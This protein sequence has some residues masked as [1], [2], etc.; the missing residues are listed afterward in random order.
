MKNVSN[1]I[2]MSSICLK[3]W[4]IIERYRVL[5]IHYKCKKVNPKSLKM[6][7]VFLQL[8]P[9]FFYVH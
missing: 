5:P 2:I 6:S 9:Y 8:H 7:Q 3:R 1:T 4:K